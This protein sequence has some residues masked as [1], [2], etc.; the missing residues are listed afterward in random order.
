MGWDAK[1]KPWPGDVL[2][3]MLYEVEEKGLDIASHGICF[4]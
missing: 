3:V 4:E 2:G 1:P